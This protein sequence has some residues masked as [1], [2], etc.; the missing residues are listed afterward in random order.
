MLLQA[1][2][3][4]AQRLGAQAWNLTTW[5]QIP[6]LPPLLDF[7]PDLFLPLSPLLEKGENNVLGGKVG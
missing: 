6:V 3:P 2:G 4:V 1:G 7:V 5:L